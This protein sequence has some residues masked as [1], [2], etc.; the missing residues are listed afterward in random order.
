MRDTCRA[1]CQRSHKYITA[2][3]LCT[4]QDVPGDSV[5]ITASDN[6]VEDVPS[7]VPSVVTV[8]ATPDTADPNIRL[9]V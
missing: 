2:H 5:G 9:G 6:D 8:G 1:T 3:M 7:S 4:A